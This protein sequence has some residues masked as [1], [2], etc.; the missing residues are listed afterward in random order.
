M[1]NAQGVLKFCQVDEFQYAPV[2]LL[3]NSYALVVDVHVSLSGVTSSAFLTTSVISTW[4]FPKIYNLI[5]SGIRN[6][7]V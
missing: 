6:I 5:L 1:P 3:V 4:T 7:T 2:C